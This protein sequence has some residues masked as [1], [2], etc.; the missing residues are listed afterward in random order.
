VARRVISEGHLDPTN[1]SVITAGMLEFFTGELPAPE[2]M[3]DLNFGARCM[4]RC[5]AIDDARDRAQNA[6]DQ[7][8]F[9]VL[10]DGGSGDGKGA[11]HSRNSDLHVGL[12]AC[13]NPVTLKPHIKPMGLKKTPRD[14]GL[15]LMQ[16][17][18]QMVDDCGFNWTYFA[19]ISGDHTEHASGDEGERQRMVTHAEVQGCPP[20]RADKFGCLRHGYHLIEGCGLKALWTTKSALEEAA[21]RIW[22]DTT[23]WWTPVATR[24]SGSRRVCRTSFGPPPRGQSPPPQ[25][26]G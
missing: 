2:H 15:V 14:T 8:G 1:F 16:T 11:I 12:A 18:V 5:G 10:T 19:G 23:S 26:G 22:E 13:V 20:G 25:S 4:A 21:R 7:N 6:R 24:S 17:D 9:F 3:C